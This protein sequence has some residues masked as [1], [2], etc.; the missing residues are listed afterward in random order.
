MNQ[1]IRAEIIK[2]FTATPNRS[3]ASLSQ[4]IASKFSLRPVQIRQVM[5][6]MQDA[7]E[8]AAI[9]QVNFRLTLKGEYFAQPVVKRYTKIMLAYIG[10]HWIAIAAILIA[11]LSF[12]KK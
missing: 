11:L 9:D 1:D 6:V 7:G 4:E 3:T 5:H 2:A 12:F 10:A 8:L